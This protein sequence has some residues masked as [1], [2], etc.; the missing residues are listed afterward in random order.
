MKPGG[1]DKF[2]NWRVPVEPAVVKM[3]KVGWG[4]WVP[5][6]VEGTHKVIFLPS[7]LRV[8]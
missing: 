7:S 4:K 8:G 1:P 2:G 5:K 6:Q 3:K